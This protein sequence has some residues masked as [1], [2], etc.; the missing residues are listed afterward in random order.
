[1][2]LFTI[3]AVVAVLSTP[4]FART[5]DRPNNTP[6]I[7]SSEAANARAQAPFAEQYRGEPARDTALRD[8]SNQAQGYSEDTWGNTESQVYRS[9]MASHGQAE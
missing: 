1:M 5:L 8:C 6:R 3:V 2:K 7:E 4:A 9:C